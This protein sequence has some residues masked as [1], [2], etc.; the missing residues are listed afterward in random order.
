MECIFQLGA[1]CRF[2][3]KEE[4]MV[5]IVPEN[6]KRIYDFYPYVEVLRKEYREDRYSFH[7]L[8]LFDMEKEGSVQKLKIV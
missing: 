6:Q 2:Q 8:I 5:Y 7:V 4:M 1:K 3:D